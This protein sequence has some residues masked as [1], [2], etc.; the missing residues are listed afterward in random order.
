MKV[1][2]VDDTPSVQLV[3]QRIIQKLGHEWSV[4]SNGAEAWDLLQLEVFDVVVVDWVMPEMDGVT[5]CRKIRSHD[6]GYY[7]YLIL[8]TSK[9]EHSDL[10]EGMNAGADDFTVK[11]PRL[12]EFAVRIRGAERICKLQSELRAQHKALQSQHTS[13]TAVYESMARDLKLAAQSLERLLPQRRYDGDPVITRY[14]FRPSSL[15]GGDFLNFFQLNSGHLIFYVFDVSGHGVPAALKSGTLCHLLNKDSELVSV[16]DG[17]R[18]PAEVA[19]RLNRLFLVDDDYFTLL[20]GVLDTHTLELRY[21][22][23]GHPSPLL[24][25]DGG[26]RFLGDGG[27]PVSLLDV[28]VFE[29]RSI[30][31][32]EGDRLYLYSD[33]IT[34][35]D[36]DEGPYGAQRLS[37]VL[38]GKSAAPLQESLDALLEQVG[39][40]CCQG[41]DDDVSILALQI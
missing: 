32:K 38:C 35:A 14:L 3:L 15:L 31:L 19:A 20:Y 27:F 2:I 34:D 37:E 16:D 17:P 4:C 1:L 12:D 25:R 41:W 8:C 13:L 7:L 39:H 22:Q 9:E 29:E 24:V 6:F 18:G 21:V 36:G 23:A 10:L 30:L 26:G 11:P 40:W 28:A 33:G 5:L